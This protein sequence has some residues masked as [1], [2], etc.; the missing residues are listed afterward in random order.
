MTYT[1]AACSFWRV[2]GRLRNR[3]SHHVYVAVGCARSLRANLEMTFSPVFALA[4]LSIQPELLEDDS[5]HPSVRVADVLAEPS[6]W[7]LEPWPPLVRPD[8]DVAW[9][10]VRGSSLAA[11]VCG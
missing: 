5:V 7:A 1:T 11:R 8:D 6:T 4:W 9:L 2:N 10:K 3:S